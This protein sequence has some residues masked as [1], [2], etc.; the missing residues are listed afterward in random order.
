MISFWLLFC[1][2]VPLTTTFVL[3]QYQKKEVKRAVKKKMIAGMNRSDLV[4]LI[5]TSDQLQ[6]D[7]KWEH[8]KEFEFKGEMYDV[9]DKRV[10]G[11]TTYYWCWWDNEETKVSKKLNHLVSM[12]FGNNHPNQQN[13]HQLVQF[14][15]TLFFNEIEPDH[16]IA[17]TELPTL[18]LQNLPVYSCLAFDP[19][20]PPPELL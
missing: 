11:D 4:L 1:F 5:F 18:A 17:N 14:L 8:A 10:S 9:V 15:Q 16:I 12:A 19:P 13:R 3:L 6:H 2:V 20:S 7:V